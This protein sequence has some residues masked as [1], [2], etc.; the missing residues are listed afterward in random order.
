[1]SQC[2]SEALA[3]ESLSSACWFYEI[4]HGVYP[5]PK[6]ETLRFTQGDKERRVQNDINGIP[7]IVT[8][9]LEGE[10]R[11]GGGITIWTFFSLRLAKLILR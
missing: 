9:S 11:D 2:H 6:I 5:E 3:E 4:L 10:G 8:Q 7:I 1:M